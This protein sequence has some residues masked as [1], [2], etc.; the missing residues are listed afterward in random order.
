MVLAKACAPTRSVYAGRNCAELNGPTVR[1]RLIRWL[2]TSPAPV[3]GAETIS[4]SSSRSHKAKATC[5]PYAVVA[6][7][8]DTKSTGRCFQVM[9]QSAIDKIPSGP[10]LVIVAISF[11]KLV[12]SSPL[13]SHK[14][15][16]LFS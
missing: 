2:S 4:V 12:Y 11:S 10:K 6:L 14:Y 13:T 15:Q 5:D 16:S 7:P 8:V 9:A 1:V 3:P